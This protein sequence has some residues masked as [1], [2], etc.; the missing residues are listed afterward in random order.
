MV[1]RTMLEGNVAEALVMLGRWTEADA[2]YERATTQVEPSTFAVYLAERWTWLTLWRGD[3][4]GALAMARRHRPVWMRHE[5]IEAQ[6][7]YRIRTTLAELA[8]VRDDLDDALDLVGIVTDSRQGGIPYVLPLLGV[9][10]RV[11]ARAREAGRDVDVAPYREVLARCAAWPTYEIWEALFDAELGARPW[12][13][14]ADHGTADGAPAHL[15]PYALWRAGQGLLA[16]GHK[17]EARSRLTA[18]V[19]AAD[20]IDAGYVRDRAVTL[21]GDA[22]P[23]VPRRG[24]RQDLVPGLDG[25]TDRERQV[26]DLVAEGLT[27]GQ[28]AERLYISRKTASV[29]VSAILRKL[30][31]ASRTEAAV[32]ARTHPRTDT[33]TDTPTGTG[34][35]TGTAK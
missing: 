6:V 24:A 10:G 33:D 25:L 3:V 15:R 13:A 12:S 32:V 31:V 2:W 34:T 30:G 7:R 26:L 18:A 27:N 28:I 5:R 23:A 4:D 22:G 19:E 8:L 14:V 21:L 16:S 35:P 11:L 1:S 20:V 9:A 17:A 29:H